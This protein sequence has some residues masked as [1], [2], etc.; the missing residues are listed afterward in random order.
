[1]HEKLNQ[2]PLVVLMAQLPEAL[3]DASNAKEIVWG[4]AE[5]AETFLIV[6]AALHGPRYLVHEYHAVKIEHHAVARTE[7]P[8]GFVITDDGDGLVR[9]ELVGEVVE[10]LLADGER[11]LDVLGGARTSNGWPARQ[12]TDNQNCFN[13]RHDNMLLMHNVFVTAPSPRQR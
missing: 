2:R 13:V 11:P 10:A 4:R 7:P 9:L 3:Q 6:V 12:R 1:M 8:E 5:V